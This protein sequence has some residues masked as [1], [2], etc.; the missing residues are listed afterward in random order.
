MS[1][2]TAASEGFAVT[3]VGGIQ[4]NA[5]TTSMFNA[6]HSLQ[7][8]NRQKAENDHQ[9]QTQIER[10]KAEFQNAS[11]PSLLAGHGSQAE[12]HQ[13]DPQHSVN[14]E[15][16][17]MAMDGRRIQPLHV[18]ESN[19][20][21]DQKTE[22]PRS[23]KVPKCDRHKKIN[24]PFVFRHPWALAAQSEIFVTFKS[25]Q[26]QRH[27]LQSTEDRAHSQHS[28]RRSAEIQV[29]HDPENPAAQVNHG[30]KDNCARGG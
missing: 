8:P 25:N 24:R 4:R 23:D 19:W 2:I 7:Q 29:V 28:R 6:G 26:S 10:P 13:A 12:K 14:A 30:G 11:F 21:I 27:N 1:P 5:H 3:V 16:C 15:E 20:R 9:D 22:E 17:G 18:I